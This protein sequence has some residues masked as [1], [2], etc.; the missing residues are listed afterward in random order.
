MSLV[1]DASVA[2]AWISPDENDAM[3]NAAMAKA[4]AEG[5]SVPSLWHLEIANILV[6]KER[7]GK[8]SSEETDAALASFRDLELTV[9]TETAYRAAEETAALARQH[10][11]SVYDAA[12]LELAARLSLPLATLDQD[13]RKAAEAIGHPLFV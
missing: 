11:L 3:A 1:I 12:Y 5:A 7:K 13:L 8:L 9:D 6:M 4:V 10:R 2:I